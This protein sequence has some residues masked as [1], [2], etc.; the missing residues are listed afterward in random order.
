MVLRDLPRL[1][2]FCIFR[3]FR[4][5]RQVVFLVREWFFQSLLNSKD[6]GNIQNLKDNNNSNT[7]VTESRENTK[8][9]SRV[10]CGNSLPVFIQILFDT[11]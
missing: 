6:S 2:P 8:L 7:H 10:T 4:G 5:T 3:Q 11:R 1:G 9:N